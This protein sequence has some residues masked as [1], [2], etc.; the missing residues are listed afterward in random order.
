MKRLLGLIVLVASILS[1]GSDSETTTTLTITGKLMPSSGLPLP[2][3]MESFSLR[4]VREVDLTSAEVTIYKEIEDTTRKSSFEMLAKGNFVNG[5]I[6][7]NESIDST[8][9]LK[10]SVDI[11]FEEPITLEVPARPGSTVSFVLVDASPYR[12]QLHLLGAS[13]RAKDSEKKFS[14]SGDMNF[15]DIDV[16]KALVTMRLQSM[17]SRETRF[18]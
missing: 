11:G 14:I 3:D 12:S 1:F 15:L 9:D 2:M 17:T 13:R 6:T 18:L 7:L 16:E 4:A 5:E 8:Q 10:I